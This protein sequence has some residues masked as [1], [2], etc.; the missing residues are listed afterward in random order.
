MDRGCEQRVDEADSVVLQLDYLSVNRLPQALTGTLPRRFGDKPHCRLG[1]RRGH[2]QRFLCVF[3]QGT[4]ARTQEQAKFTAHGEGL[5]R[6]R[7]LDA[8]L[9]RARELKR[10]ER[11]ATGRFMHPLEQRP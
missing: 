8:L 6:L 10:E 4:Q 5:A 3:W 9:K 1:H 2:E 7:L 11:V